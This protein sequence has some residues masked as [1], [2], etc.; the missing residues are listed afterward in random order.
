M[1]NCLLIPNLKGGSRTPSRHVYGIC[2]SAVVPSDV[3]KSIWRNNRHHYI[4]LHFIGK[5]SQGN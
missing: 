1:D 2:Y 5:C 3:H 4:L